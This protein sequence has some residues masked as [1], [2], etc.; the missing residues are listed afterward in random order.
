MGTKTKQYDFFLISKERSVLYGIAILLIMI[1]HAKITGFPLIVM[2]VKKNLDFGVDIFLLL[3]GISQYFSISMETSF[4]TYYLKRFTRILTPYLVVVPAWFVYADIIKE[5]SVS[6]FFLDTFLISFWTSGN[7][8][9]WFII[10]ILLMYILYPFIYKLLKKNVV[11]YGILLIICAILLNYFL[12]FEFNKLYS[13]IFILTLRIPVFILGSCLGE[14]VKNHKKLPYC[15]VYICPFLA[16]ACFVGGYFTFGSDKYLFYGAMSLF[17]CIPLSVIINR[18]N[19]NIFSK[20]FIFLGGITLEIYLIQEKV[21]SVLIQARIFK[22]PYNVLVGIVA[23]VITLFLAYWL[24]RLYNLI[25][26]AIY[27]V[28]LNEKK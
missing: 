11:A 17:L 21:Q 23:I 15:V 4:K 28:I 24:H 12:R 27:R 19:K 14:V 8:V 13:N 20:F 3:S 6:K 22:D 25:Q 10:V 1:F 26:P 9:E 18:F 16:A 2:Y 5:Q 7:R